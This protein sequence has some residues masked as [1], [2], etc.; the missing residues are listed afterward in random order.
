MSSRQPTAA[1]RPAHR[2]QTVSDPA[3]FAAV[4]DLL[5]MLL[6]RA[7]ATRADGDYVAALERTVADLTLALGAKVTETAD[8]LL[9]TNAAAAG[10]TPACIRKWHARFAIGDE[11]R[12]VRAPWISRAKLRACYALHHRGFVPA[13][14]K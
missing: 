13:G 11:G 3:L 2:Q 6:R 5:A 12:R 1:A 10:V 7:A 9:T 4:C 8:E 14:L